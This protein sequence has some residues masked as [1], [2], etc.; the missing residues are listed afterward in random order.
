MARLLEQARLAGGWHSLLRP[1]AAGD[2]LELECDSLAFKGM[3]VCRMVSSGFVVLCERALPG[4]RLIARVVRR[5][6]GFAEVR[7]C[8]WPPCPHNLGPPLILSRPPAKGR[9]PLRAPSDGAQAY[10]LRTL[11]PHRDAVDAPCTHFGDCGGCRYQNVAYGAQLAT[12]ERQV[13]ELVARIGNFGE[14]RAAGPSGDYMRPIVPCA[15]QY[16]YRNKMEFS[17]GTREWRPRSA[18][19][20]SDDQGV[21]MEAD[22]VEESSLSSESAQPTA[23]GPPAKSQPLPS[24]N[25]KG[26]ALGLHAPRRFDKI[27]PI[28]TCLLQHDSANQVLRLVDEY[29]RARQ[30]ELPAYDSVTKEGFWRHLHSDPLTGEP[31]LMVHIVT[32]DLRHDVVQPLADLIAARHPEVVTVVTGATSTLSDVSRAEKQMVLF[33][34]GTISEKLRGLHFQISASSFFQTNTEQAEVLYRMVEDACN[35]KGDGSEVVLD[36]FCGTGTIGLSLASKVRHVYG[37]ELVAE[38]VA[39][40]W[41]NAESNSISNATFV[42]GDLGKLSND[43]GASFPKPDVI[44][45]GTQPK[46]MVVL[47]VYAVVN[48]CDPNR[49]GM[50][51]KLLSFLAHS[52]APRIVYVSCNPAT[53]S[54]DL[55]IL[56]HGTEE[57]PRHEGPYQLLSVQPVDMFPHT[58]HVECVCSLE[59]RELS[60]VG[61]P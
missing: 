30:E 27:L 31:Q 4:E 41:Q 45:V 11:S 59:L 28:Q 8:M 61:T 32:S 23:E 51:R 7:S 38:A 21:V 50:S 16:H 18:V 37:F 15:K 19:D 14:S 26:F 46:D 36:L 9:L 12:K 17:F 34:P 20:C 49:P 24:A 22:G 13:Q 40:A 48:S 55:A 33:G 58:P 1:A 52:G 43:F 56:C 54:R 3:G 10:K 6:R 29:C 60:G 47:P 35:L 39:D 5:K 42:Q 25:P 53:C 57:G 44:I 2:E